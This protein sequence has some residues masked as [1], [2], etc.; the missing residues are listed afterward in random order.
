MMCDECIV[1]DLFALL[2]MGTQGWLSRYTRP[3]IILGS[4]PG[5]RA[6]ESNLL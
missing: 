3:P 6:E 1:C 4:E 5:V 2:V